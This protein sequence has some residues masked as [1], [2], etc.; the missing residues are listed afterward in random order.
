MI[1]LLHA[2]LFS[3]LAL[4]YGHHLYVQIEKWNTQR[5]SSVV[6]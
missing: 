3:D 4:F 2:D 1:F 6:G 5:L